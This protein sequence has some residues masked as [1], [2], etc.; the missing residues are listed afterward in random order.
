MPSDLNQTLNPEKAMI[1][2]ITH[3]KNVNW[4]LRNG[5]RCANSDVRDPEFVNIGNPDLIAKRRSREVPIPPGG[6]LADYVPFR[7]EADVCGLDLRVAKL[8]GWYL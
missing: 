2:R 1:F 7:A 8:S 5:L 4:L 6:T 3:R